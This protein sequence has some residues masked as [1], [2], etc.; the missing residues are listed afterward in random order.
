[1][2]FRPQP[3][4]V[5]KST[6]E[7]D[8]NYRITNVPAG[9]Y[10]VAPLAPAYVGFD[11]DSFYSS[12]KAVILGE[13]EIV[14]N[15]DFSLVRGAV[16][17][18]KVTHADGRPVIEERIIAEPAD[19][20]N[21]RGQMNYPGPPFQTDDRGVYRIFG[22]AAGRYKVAVGQAE[23]AFSATVNQ[24]RPAYERVFYPNVINADEA[25]V[26]DLAEGGEA[27]NIDIT[28]GQSIQGFA[29]SGLVIDSETNQ[30]VASVRFGLQRREAERNS[31][32]I[33]TIATSNRHGQFRLENLPPGKYAVFI[34][35]QQN[36]DMNSDPLPFE[37]V[38]QDV[39]GLI[40]RSARGASVSGAIVLE[41]T[42]DKSALAR[43]TQ[44]RIR[45]YVRGERMSAGFGQG[46]PINV[47][48]SFRLGGLQ[49]GVANFQLGTLDRTPL[50]GFV[51]SRVEREGVVLPRGLEIKSG[52]QISGVR[53]VVTYGSGIVRGTV[54]IVNGTLPVDAR[55]IVHLTKTEDNSFGMRPQEVD[56][57][58]HF[59][60]EGIP[61][62]YYNLNVNAYIPRLRARQPSAT[63]SITVN[64][65]AATEVVLVLDL[66][67]NPS[68]APNP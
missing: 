11:Q 19:D 32:L 22:L 20:P 8:G 39:T 26:I 41:G 17:T 43:L 13:G 30:P 62:G 38:D 50:T 6:T 55:L 27:T 67:P 52:E 23:E 57:R 21:Q 48:G 56:F 36:I 53:I 40:L 2:E 33:G 46:S 15:I 14:E 54:K 60:I 59:V 24:A 37:I 66:T 12:S 35:P 68:P 7:A 28:I 51:I 9:R 63:Q 64:D 31:D 18:G 47:D 16:I 34:L 49:A 3:G 29:A 61:A 65:G 1:M 58:G 10:Q 42:S 44:L 45:A 25:K 4:A 5:F